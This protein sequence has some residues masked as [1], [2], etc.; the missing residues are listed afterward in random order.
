M[1]ER[2]GGALRKLNCRHN[3]W[4]GSGSMHALP[5]KKIH[6]QKPETIKSAWMQMNMS[7]NL[8]YTCIHPSPCPAS[9]QAV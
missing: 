7:D 8:H 6:C 2:A 1:V 3:I 5:C 9:F 4:R